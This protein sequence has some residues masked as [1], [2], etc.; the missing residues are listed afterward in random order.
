MAKVC[1]IQITYDNPENSE[2]SVE[3]LLDD[4]NFHI[5]TRE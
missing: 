4:K 2:L 1:E 3:L 5:P